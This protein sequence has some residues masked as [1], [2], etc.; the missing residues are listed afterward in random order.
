[1]LNQQSQRHG[2]GLYTFAN[3]DKYE[4]NWAGDM[5]SGYGQFYYANGEMYK[6]EW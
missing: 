1:M 4:G 2:Y 5:K 3:G 6:G